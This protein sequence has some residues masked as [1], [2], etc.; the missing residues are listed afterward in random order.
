MGVSDPAPRVRPIAFSVLVTELAERIHAATGAVGTDWARVAVDGADAARPGDLAD[1]LIDPLRVRGHAVVRVCAED[2]LRPASLR[3]ERGRDDPDSFY[4]DWLDAEGLRREVLDPLAPGG[5]GV[6]RPRRW[7]AATDRAHRD[8]GVPLP[9]GG[10]LVLSGPLL[11]GR[12]LP[13]DC[14]VHLDASAAA[15]ARRTPDDLRWTL[16]AYE[17]Y[18]EEVGPTAIAD[19]VVRVDDPLH[20][21]VVESGG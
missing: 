11:L 21:A 8:A 14:V 2:H 3:F 15:L 9:P 12:G 17:R 7:D 6:V 5:S 4:E 20:P 16:P 18:A 1:A 10:V 13:L 19:V